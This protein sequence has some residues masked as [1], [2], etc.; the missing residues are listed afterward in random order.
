MLAFGVVSMLA[1][2]VYEGARAITGPYLAT[3]GASATVV[4]FVTGFGEAVAL[5]FRLFTGRLSDRT[6]RHWGL[7]IAGYT[8]TV[9][10]VPLM[11]LTSALWPAAALVVTERFGKAVRTPARDTMLAQA[12]TTTGRGKA[13]A[14]HESL[15]Q[16]G[17]LLGP[18]LV[19]AMIA[20]SGYRLGFAVL[21]VPGAVALLTLTWL[22]RAVP[23]PAAY[24][25]VHLDPGSAS[26]TAEG[27]LPVRFWLY[28]TFTAVS[29]AGSA[30][31]GVLS[32]HLQTRHVLA[33]D[34][35]P[36]TYAAAMGAAALAALAS[37]CLY[38]RFGLRGLV[39]ALPLT[40]AVPFLSFT[41]DPA[42]V[43]L[44]AIVWGAAMGIHESTLRAAVAD[45]VPAT[46]RGA[47]YGVFTAVYGLAWLVGSTLIGA[48]YGHSIAAVALFTLAT[49]AAALVLFVPLLARR[50]R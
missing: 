23:R 19:A 30:T 22:R 48:L 14:L 2:F 47:A 38:D 45:L 32:Y 35:I 18:L 7:S 12:S 16:S 49:Q 28:A 24:E 8:M 36:I 42:L 40:A 10:A 3:L 39:I 5:V 17:A 11:A 31:F 6:G 34:L 20:A 26:A 50:P 29:M 25:A 43:W 33:D 21:A 27:R 1:D 37:G 41:T 9:V 44:G 15:D 46:R 13:F 4:G